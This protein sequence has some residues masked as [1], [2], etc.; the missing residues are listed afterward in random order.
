M[1]K[2]VDTSSGSALIKR[3]RVFFCGSSS[4]FFGIT[5]SPVSAGLDYQQIETTL[6][7][8]DYLRSSLHRLSDGQCAVLSGS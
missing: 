5:S 2:Y 8:A 3:H 4:N 7:K 6:L 1:D